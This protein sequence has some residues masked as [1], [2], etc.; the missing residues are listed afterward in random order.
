MMTIYMS[1]AFWALVI[2]CFAGF[3]GLKYR[4]SPLGIL[5]DT[6]GRY[7]LTHFQLV[8]WSILV[9]SLI[10]AVVAGK[11]W[12]GVPNALAFDI[13][14]NLLGVMGISVVS[15]AAAIAVKSGKDA[16][17]PEQIAAS[18]DDDKPC[19]TQ[20]FLVEEGE[21]ADKVVDVSKFQNFWFTIILFVAY[22]GL[23]VSA[24]NHDGTSL[25][26]LPDFSGTF[27]ALLGISHAGYIAGKGPARAG[28]PDGLTLAGKRAGAKPILAAQ[29]A[30]LGTATAPAYVPRNPK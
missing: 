23:A 29:A 25:T 11:L 15:T 24:I 26:A 4:S 5:I 20:M 1:W 8:L 12:A 6:R 2:I 14:N 16:K 18:N 27:V 21:F 30:A 19:L 9:L 22:I 13:P 7:S 28:K 3:L 17:N 10:A